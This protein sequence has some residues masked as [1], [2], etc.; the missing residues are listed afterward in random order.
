MYVPNCNC[1]YVFLILFLKGVAADYEPW[2]PSD[3]INECWMGQQVTYSRR[4]RAANCNDTRGELL[5]NSSTCP[6]AMEDYECDFG[7]VA[8]T[9]GTCTVAGALPPSPPAICKDTYEKSQGFRIV[10]GDKCEGGLDKRP[11]VLQCPELPP[12]KSSSSKGWVAVVVIIVA[13]VVVGLISFIVY[14]D[15]V[16]KEKVLGLFRP[17]RSSRY[18]RLGGLGGRGR[19]S[20]LAHEEDFGIHDDLLEEGGE[21]DAK[22]LH[23]NDISKASSKS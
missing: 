5:L 18:G 15:P 13:L 19:S 6:C 16:M 21:E 2:Y 9:G 1:F 3:G 7:F 8:G 11:Q 22:V 4:I 17:S 14:R 12:G 23:D 10:P 20:S